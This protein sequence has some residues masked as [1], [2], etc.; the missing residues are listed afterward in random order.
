[1]LRIACNRTHIRCKY[2]SLCSYNPT[3]LL[4]ELR[5]RLRKHQPHHNCKIGAN[6]RASVLV[7][8]IPRSNEKEIYDLEILLSVRSQSLRLHPGELCF[9]G[10]K[11]DAQDYTSLKTGLREVQEELGIEPQS[12]EIIG[13]LDEIM[14]RSMYLVTPYVGILPINYDLDNMKFSEEV[15][16]VVVIPVSFLIK[17]IRSMENF[18]KLDIGKHVLWGMTFHVLYR[19]L[20]VGFGIATPDQEVKI[21]EKLTETEP[22]LKKKLLPSH[23]MSRK[24]HEHSVYKGW[25]YRNRHGR[26]ISGIPWMDLAQ[27]ITEDEQAHGRTGLHFNWHFY[28][29]HS[30]GKMEHD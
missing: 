23:A 17:H 8:I 3:I 18:L 26:V 30:P 29:S 4:D 14:S 19:L 11:Q 27:Y 25:T 16:D 20:D 12:I 2:Y 1:M 21:V 7:P 24:R 15:D 9:P 22:S 13:K 10:G 28:N 5:N 6:G